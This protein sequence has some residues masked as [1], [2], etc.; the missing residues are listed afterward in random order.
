MK[1]RVGATTGLS[2]KKGPGAGGGSESRGRSRSAATKR[3]DEEMTAGGRRGPVEAGRRDRFKF[4]EGN[5]AIYIYFF[6]QKSMGRK[7]STGL[8]VHANS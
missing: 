4:Q 8:F 2:G 7:V 3:G 5:A 1:C 6:D